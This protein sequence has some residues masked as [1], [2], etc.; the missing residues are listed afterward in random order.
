M[1]AGVFNNKK[2][3]PILTE[4]FIGG[5]KTDISIVFI[6]KSYFKVP[7]HVTLNSTH[8]LP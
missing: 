1:I 5:R 6:T 8:F 2:L 7:N 4:W 3:N